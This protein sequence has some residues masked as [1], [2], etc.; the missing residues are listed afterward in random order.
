MPPQVH[1]GTAQFSASRPSH[2]P[3]SARHDVVA[4]VVAQQRRFIVQIVGQIRGPVAVR[5]GQEHRAVARRVEA[6]RIEYAEGGEN[7][8]EQREQGQYDGGRPQRQPPGAVEHSPTG[9]RPGRRR[10]ECRTTTRTI[11]AA[12]R[13]PAAADRRRRGGKRRAARRRLRRCRPLRTTAAATGQSRPTPGVLGAS[14][15]ARRGASSIDDRPRLRSLRRGAHAKMR[16]HPSQRSPRPA[17]T[18]AVLRVRPSPVPA[19]SALGRQPAELLR[20]A[21]GPWVQRHV[22]ERRP[23]E[24]P[25]PRPAPRAG[26]SDPPRRSPCRQALPACLRSGAVGEIARRRRLAFLQRGGRRRRC[27]RC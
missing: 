2:L 21:A 27:R 18:G 25:S 14:R 12:R 7:P 5:Q 26:P 19:A 4:D 1:N 24:G 3:A 10:R 15:L 11:P 22:H 20:L 16:Q 23:V 13:P 8:A 9:Q 6:V 17:R